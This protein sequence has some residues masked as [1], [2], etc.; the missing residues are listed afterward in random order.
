MPLKRIILFVFAL[1]FSFA[2][3]I[4]AQNQGSLNGQVTDPHGKS[5]AGAKIHLIDVTTGGQTSRD[6]VTTSSGTYNFTQV[7]PGTYKLQVEMDGFKTFVQEKVEVLVSTPTTL[8]IQLQ[9]GQVTEQ[10]VVTAE[11]APEINAT[12]ATIGNTFNEKQVKELPFLARNVVGLLALQPGVVFT[13]DSNIDT[14]SLGSNNGLDMREGA[15]NGVRGNQMNITI[16]GGDDN[17]WQNQAA[18]TSALPVTLDSVQEF[19]VTTSGMNST[20]GVASGAQIALVT[21]SGTN[22]FHGNVRWNYRTAGPTANTYFNNATGIARPNLVRNIGGGSLGGPIFKDRI[23]FFADFEDRQERSQIPVGP[24]QVASASLRDGVLI[25]QC[26]PTD[27]LFSSCSGGTVQGLSGHMWPVPAGAFGLTPAQ[28]QTIDPG[29]LGVNPN[30]LAYMALFPSGNSPAQSNDGGLAFNAF[31]FNSAQNFSTNVYT[32]RMDINITRDGHHTAFVRG[33]MG[34]AAVDILPSQFPGQ[35]VASALLNNSRGIAAGYTAQFSPTLINTFHY[36][37]TRLGEGESGNTGTAFSIRFFDTNVAF[38]R[39]FSRAVPTHE[40]RDDV[41]WSH[42]KHTVQFGGA[43]RLIQNHRID[44]SL[45]FPSFT[46]NPGSCNDCGTLQNNL[47]SDGLP[48]ASNVNNFNAAFLMLTGAITEAHA[49]AFGDPKTGTILPPGTPASRNF[50]ENNFEGFVQD[51]WKIKPNF[52]VTAGVRYEYATPVW[53]TNG[54]EVAPTIDAF[55]WLMQREANAN[56]GIGA[57]ASPLL[58][59]APAGKAN[60]KPSWYNPQALDFSPHVAFA[61]SPGYSEGFLSHL[62]GGAGKSSIRGGFGLYHD[63]VG[64]AIAVDSDLNGSPGTATSLTNPLN[65]FGLSDAPRFSGNCN[66]TTGCTGLPSLS[67]YINL[68]TSATFPFQPSADA[69][70]TDF[71]V[72]PHLKTPYVMNFSLGIQREIGKGV[73]LDVGY[74]GTLGRRL[75]V[76]ADYAEFANLKDPAS[77][78]TVWQAYRAVA[79]LAG[80]TFSAVTNPGIDPTNFAAL[81]TIQNQPFFEHMMA[82]MPT[83][84]AQFFCAPSDAA[85]NSNYTGLSPTQAFYSFA[86]QDLATTLGSPS[87]SC[88][89]FLADLLPGFGFQTPWS[90]SVDPTN[91]GFVLFPPQFNGL[92]GWTNFGSSN[93]HSLQVGVRKNTGRVTFSANYVFSKSIDNASAPENGDLIPGSNGAFS[94]LIYTPFDLRQGRAVSDFNLTHNFIGSFGYSLP[95]GRG[96][97]FGGSA[98][99]AKDALIGGWEVT[100]I[101]RMRS[102]FPLSPSNGFNFPTDFFLTTPATVVA[103]IKSQITRPTAPGGFPNLFAN[104]PAALNAIGPTQPGLSGSRNVIT[105]PAYDDVDMDV[106]KYFVMPW[107]EHQRMQIRVS[108]YNLFNTVNFSDGLSLDPTIPNTFGQFVGTIGSSRSGAR[109]IEFGARFDF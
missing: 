17:D 81:H 97:R 66:N 84:A 107:S 14:L 99:R 2:A 83:M 37:F 12:D 71:V 98:G 11:A 85:C 34:G 9:L 39:G 5:V 75:L 64:Q 82:N 55:Q 26:D 100:G 21:K 33:I 87:W 102:G 23:F 90:N 65:L 48:T 61:W 1:T 101:V 31:D 35:P 76:K 92:A 27:P 60:G 104:V 6:G 10:V 57:N 8:N 24:R 38:N 94:G 18:F 15:V 28:I 50:A 51:S 72:D 80:N 36:T 88:A 19:R 105:G 95:F 13:G 3:V 74:V 89:L 79:S 4:Q 43:V 42:G 96:R 49:T 32:A 91:G 93:F 63:R 69:S 20:D 16:D 47:T 73:V 67:S 68:P 109:E 77:G 59:W 41:S 44:N 29:A 54:F 86:I 40:F 62:F 25:Y 46:S 22:N 53:E 45:S 7:R 30:M 56:I 78:Q 58:S 106:H 108:A 70:N 103:P 52:T